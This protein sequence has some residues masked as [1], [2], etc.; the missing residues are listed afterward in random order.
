MGTVQV[1]FCLLTSRELT[2]VK[3]T[4][5]YVADDSGRVMAFLSSAP[6]ASCYSTFKTSSPV[7]PSLFCGTCGSWLVESSPMVVGTSDS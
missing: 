6:A 4:G 1:S 7:A 5:S 3:S 2:A